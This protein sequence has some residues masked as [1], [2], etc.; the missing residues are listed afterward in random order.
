MDNIKERSIIALFVFGNRGEYCC[1][2]TLLLG[3]PTM[4]ACC[5]WQH[6]AC[7]TCTK[8]AT[9]SFLSKKWSDQLLAMTMKIGIN[10]STSTPTLIFHNQLRYDR[11]E[12][13]VSIVCNIFQGYFRV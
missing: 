8:P 12:Q 4:K 11:V 13:F 1:K 6:K 5:E 2:D 9:E 3:R 10:T 7:E